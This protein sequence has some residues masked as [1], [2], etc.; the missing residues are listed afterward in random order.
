M[1]ALARQSSISEET[2]ATSLDGTPPR[3]SEDGKEEGT[4]LGGEK[5][6]H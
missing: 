1:G 5:G 4:H 3:H 2:V 6:T